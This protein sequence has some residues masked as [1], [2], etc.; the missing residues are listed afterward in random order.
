M[1]TARTCGSAP[2]PRLRAGFMGVRAGNPVRVHHPTKGDT[3]LGLLERTE[4]EVTVR[5]ST[6]VAAAALVAGIGVAATLVLANGLVTPGQAGVQ[7]TSRSV[8]LPLSSPGG[9]PR[10]CYFV[11]STA[12]SDRFCLALIPGPAG[13]LLNGTFDHGPTT[14][15][16]TIQIPEGPPCVSNCR[17]SATWTSVD[18][19]GQI[20]WGFNSSVAL[21]AL[22]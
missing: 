2:G 15:K 20:L 22:D 16:S 9:E 12:H 6:W 21:S 3:W 8:Q 1:K 17:T 14:L 4:A 10:Y 19:T 7:W 18:R 5:G 11:N 13:Y